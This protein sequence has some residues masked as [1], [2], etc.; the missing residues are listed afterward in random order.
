MRLPGGSR[1]SN[2]SEAWR[3][4]CEVAAL[5]DGDRPL[6]EVAAVAAR[7][8]GKDPEAAQRIAAHLGALVSNELDRR[9]DPPDAA[10]DA[11]ARAVLALPDKPARRARLDEVEAAEGPLYRADV[12]RAVR[13][14]WSASR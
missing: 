1:V 13:A 12:E 4:A 7:R 10:V 5:C 9:A 14:L 8:S 6:T 11:E 2:W 3:E